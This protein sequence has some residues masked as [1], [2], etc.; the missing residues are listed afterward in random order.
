M[1][2]ALS[3]LLALAALLGTTSAALA[4]DPVA[5]DD[6]LVHLLLDYVLQAI[7]GWLFVLAVPALILAAVLLYLLLRRWRHVTFLDEPS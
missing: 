5:G 1:R 3:L 7:P 2:L 6:P 4:H